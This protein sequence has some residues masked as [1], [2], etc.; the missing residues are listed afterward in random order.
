MLRRTLAAQPDRSVQYVSV[1]YATNLHDLLLSSGDAHSP[2]SG[3]QLVASKVEQVVIMGG[4][5]NHIEWN[6]AVQRRMASA[7]WRTRQK[8]CGQHN[9]LVRSQTARSRCCRRTSH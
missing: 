1:G 3:A 2:L 6:I 9:H 8:L 7:V 5:K 4:R